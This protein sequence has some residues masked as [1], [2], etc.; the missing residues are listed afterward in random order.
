[1]TNGMPVN[2]DRVRDT[3]SMGRAMMPAFGNVLDPQQMD[4]VIAYLHAM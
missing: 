1:M 4:D 3:I 2:D